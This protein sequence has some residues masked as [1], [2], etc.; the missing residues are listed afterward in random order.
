MAAAMKSMQPAQHDIWN[1]IS[2]DPYI[3]VLYII[4]NSAE[5]MWENLEQKSIFS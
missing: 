4:L 3:T 5:L 1:N 2:S